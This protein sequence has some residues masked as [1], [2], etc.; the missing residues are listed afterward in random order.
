[1]DV[2]FTRLT[3]HTGVEVSGID[4]SAPVD[5]GM[6]A[7]LNQ[8]FVDSGV[9]VIRGQTLSPHQLLVPSVCLVMYFRNTIPDSL[10]LTVQRFTLSP[11][12]TNSRT[13]A[14]TF[15]AKD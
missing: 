4:M 15:R 2:T 12:R 1:M 9:L 3:D 14:G 6:R 11:I 7:R 5:A 13:G 10:C 8:A